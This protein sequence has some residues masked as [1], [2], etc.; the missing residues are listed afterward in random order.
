MR[1]LLTLLLFYIFLGC[2]FTPPFGEEEDGLEA[3]TARCKDA[4]AKGLTYSRGT[5]GAEKCVCT[6]RDAGPQ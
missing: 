3:C 5:L 1:K 2:T 6:M 4:G